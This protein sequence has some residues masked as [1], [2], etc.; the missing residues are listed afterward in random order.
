MNRPRAFAGKTP[1]IGEGVF[2]A[3]TACVIGDV[4]IGADSSIW[5]GTV[6]RGDVGWIRIG[7]RTNV[8][9]LTMVHVT[10]GLANTTIG[11]DVT[12][13]HRAI[14]HGCTVED[15]CL[16]GMGAIV[17]DEA[18]IGAGS[19]VAAGALVT[20]GTRVPPRSLVLGSPA[21]V[22]RPLRADEARMGIDGAAR[23]LELSRS[24]LA[25]GK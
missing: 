17:M 6:V 12:I 21:K 13:G 22:V 18:V 1:A 8:Q 14:L 16:I 25:E 3:A 5:F 24:Y 4:T 9:D 20:P 7:R 15:G 2:L 10:G 19:L 11:D 23:Y